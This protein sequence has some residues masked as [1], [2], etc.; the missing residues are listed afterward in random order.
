LVSIKE[1][2]YDARPTKS[3]DKNKLSVTFNF[4][5]KHTQLKTAKLTTC[6]PILK[7][8]IPSPLKLN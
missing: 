7:T 6:G 3:Q 8:E 2:Y 1:L 5:E 4:M